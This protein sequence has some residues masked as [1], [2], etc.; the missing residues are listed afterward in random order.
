MDIDNKFCL[1]CKKGNIEFAKLILTVK[2]NIDISAKNEEAFRLSCENG[3]L[4]VAQWLQSLKPHIYVIKNK[5]KIG[6]YIQHYI[7]TNEEAIW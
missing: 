7:R 6:T 4:E 2:P 5:I 1:A 3:H